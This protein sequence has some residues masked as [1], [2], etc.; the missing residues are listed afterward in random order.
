MAGSQASP[1]R[2]GGP[3][4]T[5]G[6]PSGFGTGGSNPTLIGNPNAGGG[7]ALARSRFLVGDSDGF[8]GGQLQGASGRNA[9]KPSDGTSGDGQ[10]WS[11][12]RSKRPGGAGGAAAAAASAAQGS[13]IHGQ[14][15]Q[16]TASRGI[17]LGVQGTSRLGAAGSAAI[18]RGMG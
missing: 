14:G 3:H 11:L 2:F 6:S 5:Q 13:G 10:K 9:S 7:Q 8:K 12:P 16:G 17:G 4:S 15:G 18:G 1:A